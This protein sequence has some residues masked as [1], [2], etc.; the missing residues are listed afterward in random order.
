MKHILSTGESLHITKHVEYKNGKKNKMAGMTSLNTSSLDNKFCEAMAKN[1]SLVCR[2]CYARKLESFRKHGIGKVFVNNSK[3]LSK[4]LRVKDIPKFKCKAVRFNSFGEIINVAHYKNMLAIAEENPDTI[5]ALWTKRINI[6]RK[7]KKDL[8]NM[9]HIYSSPE[10][11]KISDPGPEFDKVFTVF[12]KAHVREHDIDM[13]CS[14]Q[15]LGCKL[16]YTHNKTR[17]INE[18]L[19]SA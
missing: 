8:P 11:N 16:C 10:V 13:N 12:D 5:F 3:I 7:Y 6:V 1:K 19:R 15:C 18:R 4:K 2:T 9:L 17:Y 14:E